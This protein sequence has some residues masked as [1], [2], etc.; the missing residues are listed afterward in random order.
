[1]MLVTSQTIARGMYRCRQ[2]P[3]LA[4]HRCRGAPSPT[5]LSGSSMYS[6][7]RMTHAMIH[8]MT[9]L[10]LVCQRLEALEQLPQLVG[11]QV[12]SELLELGAQ[13]LP[14]LATERGRGVVGPGMPPDM[15]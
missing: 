13:R 9:H 14:A 5:L 6:C 15:R 10:L 8:I 2:R 7:G 1:M 4:S 12:E 3:H 11:G